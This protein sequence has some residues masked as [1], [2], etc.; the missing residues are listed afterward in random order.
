MEGT[1]I[2]KDIDFSVI[3]KLQDG[4]RMIF[5]VEIGDLPTQKAMEYLES[6]RNTFK[7]KVALEDGDHYFFAP[8][9]HGQ[10]TVDVEIVKAEQK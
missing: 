4:E 2:T 6:I 10:K 7:E 1:K 9:R 5:Y 8:M 3:P